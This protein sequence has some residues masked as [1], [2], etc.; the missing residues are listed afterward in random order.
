GRAEM[1]AKIASRRIAYDRDLL[2]GVSAIIDDVRNR[3]DEALIEYASRFDG[4]ELSV[5]KLRVDEIVWRKS[6]ARADA[7]F[8]DAL[9]ESIQNVRAFHQQQI[10]RSWEFNPT[11]GLM[12]GQ[13][14]TPIERAG[15]YV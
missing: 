7:R 12:L 8:L 9:R 13:R 5:E 15:V 1:L 3:G 14:V 2:A 11:A 10:E 6:A 4:V